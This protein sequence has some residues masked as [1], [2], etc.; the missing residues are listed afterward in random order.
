MIYELK[1]SLSAMFNSLHSSTNQEPLEKHLCNLGSHYEKQAVADDFMLRKGSH[2]MQPPKQCF[3][4]SAKIN[5]I[6][7]RMLV[8]PWRIHCTNCSMPK[9]TT[10]AE[11]INFEEWK[12]QAKLFF[13]CCV[14][15]SGV[16]MCML[17]ICWFLYISYTYPL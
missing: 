16:C 5:G 6:H 11:A 1:Y 10:W 13:W 12:N 3:S 17:Y 9:G 14:I 8:S 2:H 7:R 15:C 4:L